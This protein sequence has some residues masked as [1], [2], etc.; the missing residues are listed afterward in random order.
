MN[1]WHTWKIADEAVGELDGGLTGVATHAG[2]FGADA[3]DVRTVNLIG[4]GEPVERKSDVFADHASSRDGTFV[5]RTAMR[6]HVP[7][8]GG[9]DVGVAVDLLKRGETKELGV[10]E[11]LDGQLDWLKVAHA[12]QVR[13]ILV[14]CGSAARANAAMPSEIGSCL[15]I[16][17]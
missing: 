4:C 12:L 10:V 1:E 17:L 11:L 13:R 7:G 16:K 8:P 6:G 9:D 15:E 14:C 2:V 3:E 5:L